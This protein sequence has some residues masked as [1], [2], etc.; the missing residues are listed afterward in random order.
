[1]VD[2]D[3]L[4]CH[5]LFHFK[6]RNIHQ[7]GPY[8]LFNKFMPGQ[9]HRTASSLDLFCV[10]LQPRIDFKI[11]EC[12]CNE[13]L[14]NSLTVS[15]L[16]LGNLIVQIVQILQELAAWGFWSWIMLNRCSIYLTTSHM[17]EFFQRSLLKDGINALVLRHSFTSP[18]ICTTRLQRINVVCDVRQTK[19]LS[20]NWKK[21][22]IHDGLTPQ[23]YESC[24]RQIYNK[25]QQ[26]DF[27]PH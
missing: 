22:A 12:K 26:S 3:S 21:N 8:L 6:P 20:K 19:R 7:I 4:D 16:R 11:S 18:S 14:M 13:T 1:M 9:I 23:L 15:V 17:N 2:L 10:Y 5:I 25:V 24:W 27:E